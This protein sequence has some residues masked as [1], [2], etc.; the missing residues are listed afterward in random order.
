[1]RSARY[2]V[3]FLA[4]FAIL[5]A[6][7]SGAQQP[8]GGG[9]SPSTSVKAT[10][11]GTMTFALEDQPINMDPLLSNAFIDRNIHYQIYDS[12][13][14]IDSSGKIIP[15]LATSWDFSSDGKAVT[16]HLRTDVKY[17]DGE[18]FDAASVKWNID[19]YRTTT[20]SQRSGELASVDSV[21]VVDASTVR[22][23][24]KSVFAPLLANLVDRS[25]MMLSRK[26]V[27]AG[28]TDFT[29]KPSKAG[30]GPFVLT[31][32]VQNDHM[33][34]EKNPSYWLKDKDG[35]QLPYLDK[36]TVKPITDGTV[37]LTNVRTGDA[38]I[39]NNIPGKDVASLKTDS[40]LVYQQKEAYQFNS[41][42]PNEAAGYVFADHRYVKAVS[43]TIDRQQI[44]DTIA[45]GVGAVGYGTIAPSH[46]AFDPTFKPYAKADPDGAKAL[47]AQIGAPLQFEL[48]IVSGDPVQLQEAQLIKAQLEKAGITMDITQLQ[49]A[50]ILDLQNKHTF[51][52][53]TLIGWSGR[54]DPDGNTYDW[55]YT[56]RP[57]NAESYSNKQ[58]DQLLDHSRATTDQEQRKSDFQKA[59]QIF[60]VDDPAAVWFGFGVSQLLY[61]PKLK[62][63]DIYPDR[64]VRFATAWLQK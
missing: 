23:N 61:T 17:A 47:I 32:F 52:G 56:G 53:M 42:I 31:E 14:R 34:L 27:E 45:F 12:L 35:S 63:M 7:C 46:F 41:M 8:S 55:V 43:M 21:D 64:L 36:V 22:F 10:P 9:A 39:M 16:F 33:T 28:G 54:I 18:T 50:Q 15:W 26:S 4:S 30:S 60:V 2:L 13:V 37:R 24:L 48:L 1:M 59:Q 58:V 11:G 62:G 25:G 49:F 51:K 19:R 57:N 3:A 29:R 5:L 6:A 38:Q 20:G 40:T 44:L